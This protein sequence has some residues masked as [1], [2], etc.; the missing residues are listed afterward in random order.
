MIAALRHKCK[1]LIRVSIEDLELGDLKP[2]AVREIEESS[3]FKQL[4]IDTW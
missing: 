4:K 1:R 2:G 3:F